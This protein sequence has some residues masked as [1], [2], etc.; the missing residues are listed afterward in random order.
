MV[1]FNILAWV[2]AMDAPK[3]VATPKA[4]AAPKPTA[5]SNQRT[6]Q[7]EKTGSERKLRRSK[8]DYLSIVPPMTDEEAAL[9]NSGRQQ[10]LSFDVQAFRNGQNLQSFP[11]GTG[12]MLG[13]EGEILWTIDVLKEKR[14]Y[15]VDEYTGEL[16]VKKF[17]VWSVL[18]DGS[19]DEVGT[20]SYTKGE[21]EIEEHL[22]GRQVQKNRN[23]G[24]IIQL[25]RCTNS[26]IVKLP[27]AEIHK[28]ECCQEEGEETFAI[29]KQGQLSYKGLTFFNTSSYDAECVGGAR[30]FNSVYRCEQK[31]DNGQI[32]EEKIT[33]K[34]VSNNGKSAQFTLEFDGMQIALNAVRSAETKF[35]EGKPLETIYNL[36]VAQNLRI[37]HTFSSHNLIGIAQI[38]MGNDAD[39]TSISFLSSDG[40][41]HFKARTLNATPSNV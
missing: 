20:L 14:E 30:V 18:E 31:W 19:L 11:N 16:M 2:T 26:E 8:G 34:N 28:R 23:T 35:A 40:V 37:E 15:K 1:L 7:A 22:D 27:T 12:I 21:F 10:V 36:E 24:V 4:V 41:E 13:A 39:E 38:R 25:D 32:V 5:T 33:F 9:Y 29:W 3:V 6:E 17:G